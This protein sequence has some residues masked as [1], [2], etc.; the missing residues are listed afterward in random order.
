[1]N[2]TDSYTEKAL[3]TFS[4]KSQRLTLPARIIGKGAS[5]DSS[6]ALD[7]DHRALK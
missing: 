4:S 2:L 1:M 3:S 5:P 7:S 6:T